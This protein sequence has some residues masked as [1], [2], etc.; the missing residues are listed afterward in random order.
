MQCVPGTLFPSLSR[1]GVC[2]ANANII[3]VKLKVPEQALG[4]MSQFLLFNL[5]WFKPFTVNLEIFMQDFNFCWMSPLTIFLCTLCIDNQCDQPA[6]AEVSQ[7][8]ANP[9]NWNG[10]AYMVVFDAVAFLLQYFLNLLVGENEGCSGSH[11]HCTRKSVCIRKAIS[12]RHRQCYISD[13]RQ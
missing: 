1:L 10:G 8:L 4:Q 6:E 11:I 3:S 9:N 12:D 5:I 2:Q 13:N 7:C